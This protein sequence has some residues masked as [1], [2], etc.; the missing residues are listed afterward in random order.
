[1]A[2]LP[3]IA[4]KLVQSGN[5]NY[6][7]R[8]FAAASFLL[9]LVIVLF[10]IAR[11]IGGWGPGHLSERGLRRVRE[12]SARDAERFARSQAARDVAAFAPAPSG[13]DA[14]SP[15]DPSSTKDTR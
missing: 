10:V 3:L 8:A 15:P 11:K 6:T 13:W 5:A 14:T 2:S 7:A 12:A 1:M 4:L 9:L